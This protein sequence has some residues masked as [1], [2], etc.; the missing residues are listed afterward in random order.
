MAFWKFTPKEF[1]F[2]NRNSLSCWAEQLSL[3]IRKLW[4]K[5]GIIHFQK[6]R[7]ENHKRLFPHV[8]FHNILAPKPSKTARLNNLNHYWQILENSFKI[9][10][11]VSVFQVRPISE[12]PPFLPRFQFPSHQLD[13]YLECLS[14]FGKWPWWVSEKSAWL[15][16]RNFAN[17]GQGSIIPSEQ[18]KNENRALFW[19][20]FVL[21]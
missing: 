2:H 16:P 3:G 8:S 14:T 6:P 9:F 18:I 20:F 13:R 12:N 15:M 19:R 10:S 5:L 4:D 21:K 11:F 1:W 7:I 17:N